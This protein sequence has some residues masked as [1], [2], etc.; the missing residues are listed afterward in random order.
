MASVGTATAQKLVYALPVAIDISNNEINLADSVSHGHRVVVEALKTQL[1]QAFTWS[2]AIG[3]QFPLAVV[4][5]DKFATELA[6]ALARGYDDLDGQTNGLDFTS[7]AL[8]VVRS[9]GG[10]ER[11][12]ADP[13]VKSV[14]DWVVA[15]V[16]YKLYGRSSYPTKDEIFNVE[17]MHSMLTD[18]QVAGAVET[19]LVT[20][21]GVAAVKKLFKDLLMADPKRFFD[22]SGVQIEGLFEVNTDIIGSGDWN[23]VEDDVIEIRLNFTFKNAITRRD[24]GDAQETADDDLA[25]PDATKEIAAN[26]TFSIRL[27]VKAVASV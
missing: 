22:A 11:L 2:R 5:A 17:D 3:D 20:S 27:Q 6:A 7:S 25:T 26:E 4:D 13:L 19:K 24:I 10:D 23:I 12:R 8:N 14:N 1:N 9:A 21:E 16:L 15:Y 18:A